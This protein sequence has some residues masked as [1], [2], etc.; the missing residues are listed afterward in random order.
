MATTQP[1]QDSG[2]DTEQ[3]ND[4]DSF[5][6]RGR[7]PC[8]SHSVNTDVDGTVVAS[9]ETEGHVRSYF[10]TDAILDEFTK[11]RRGNPTLLNGMEHAPASTFRAMVN[12]DLEEVEC[13]VDY[14]Q[15]KEW[16]V[17]FDADVRMWLDFLTDLRNPLD[18]ARTL[19]ESEY[20]SHGL[21]AAVIELERRDADPLED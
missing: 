19:Q 11:K 10:S 5:V 13:E 9:H 7:G 4:S 1:T 17:N 16:T 3:R 21:D 12:E 20:F 18:D 6:L 2:N 14:D 15:F 8:T